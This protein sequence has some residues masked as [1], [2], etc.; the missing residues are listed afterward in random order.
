[1]DITIPPP[2]NPKVFILAIVVKKW[3][4][5]DEDEPSQAHAHIPTGPPG[6]H[7]TL[8]MASLVS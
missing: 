3:Q 6:T 8:E 4:G 2:P 1:M 7:K 5:V